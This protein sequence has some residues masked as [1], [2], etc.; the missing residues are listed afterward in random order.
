MRQME[1]E[2][3][4]HAESTSTNP[5]EESTIAYGAPRQQTLT[6]EQYRLNV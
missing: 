4:S 5:G 1:L 2:G 3:V 6:T